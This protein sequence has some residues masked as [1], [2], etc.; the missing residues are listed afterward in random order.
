MNN[1]VA[2]RR[3][4][5]LL[6][7]Y[8]ALLIIALL[9]WTTM[10]VHVGAIA[11]IPLLFI[12]YYVRPAAALLTAFAS[13]IILALLDLNVIFPHREPLFVPPL[14]DILILSAALCAVVLIAN[15]LREREMANEVLR[16]R[17]LKARREAEH[18]PLTG[19][20]NRAAFRAILDE[21]VAHCGK[22]THVAVLFC[23]LDGFKIVND[24]HGH[25][26]GD[27]LLQLAAGRLVNTVRSID[28]VGRIGGDEFAIVAEHINHVDEA[29]HMSANIE[30]AFSDP[31]HADNERYGIGITAGVSLYPDDGV[32]AE[33][34]LRIADE[35]MYRAK[36]EK[37]SGRVS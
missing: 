24:V 22:G 27:R 36:R 7:S 3:T 12:A 5:I 26:A 6:A 11:V 2:K 8:G 35:R 18:D 17:L 29:M 16:G 25:L 31:F 4:A 19:I 34:L 30:R 37:R 15:R 20:V 32:D 13:G 9:A 10:Q 33:T 1:S 28:T 14:L 21:A 23:D